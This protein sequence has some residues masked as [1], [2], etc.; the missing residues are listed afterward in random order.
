V[1]LKGDDPNIITQRSTEHLFMPTM[2]YEIG[3]GKW[4]VQRKRTI[5]T[6]AVVPLD[7]PDTFRVWY[8]AADAN[9][10]WAVIQVTVS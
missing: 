2:D 8:G 5:F 4:P 7:L 1:I 3:N 10:A 9:V 6:T